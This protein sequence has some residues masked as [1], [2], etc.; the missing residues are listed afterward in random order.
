MKMTTINNT[1]TE[2]LQELITK[3]H[4]IAATDIKALRGIVA[5]QDKEIRSLRQHL[6]RVTD[7]LNSIQQIAG[8]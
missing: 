7:S 4:A 2:V 1:P 6:A 8:K 3:R 5:N